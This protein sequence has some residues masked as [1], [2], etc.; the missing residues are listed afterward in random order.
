VVRLPSAEAGAAKAPTASPPG[1]Q[2]RLRVLVVDDN[3]DAAESLADLIRLLGHEVDVAHEGPSA[4]ETA[5]ARPPDVVLCDIGLPAMSGYDV[6]RALRSQG[7]RA[8]L[9]AVSG[10]AQPEDVARAAEAGFDRHVAKP[11]SPAEI[12]RLLS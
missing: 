10:Y 12:E 3:R 8:R 7:A 1:P 11:P 6:A 9:V 4:L 5:R 2:R